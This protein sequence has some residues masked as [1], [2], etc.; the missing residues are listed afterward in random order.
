MKLCL[1]PHSHVIAPPLLFGALLFA[2]GFR[3]LRGCGAL[4]V[5][6]VVV[7]VAAVLLDADA[8]IFARFA[9]CLYRVCP[10]CLYR[11]FPFPSFS[12]A[13]VTALDTLPDETLRPPK[14]GSP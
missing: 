11:V 13:A 9:G 1:H 3:R 14:P 7:V 12:A 5:V 2:L 8:E 10:G 4:L 6:V